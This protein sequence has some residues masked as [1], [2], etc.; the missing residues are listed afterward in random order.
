VATTTT[1][2]NRLLGLVRRRLEQFGLPEEGIAIVAAVSGGPDSV[3][4]AHLLVTL[5]ESLGLTLFIAHLNHGLRGEEAYADQV[6]VESLARQMS[7]PFDVEAIHLT[8]LRQSEGGNLQDLARRHRYAFLQKVA[9]RR[10]TSWIALGHTLDDQAET[11]LLAMV[12]GAGRQGLSGMPACRRIGEQ[13]IIRP[14]IDVER[15]EIIEFLHSENLSYR[16]DSSNQD[17]HYRR[18]RLRHKVLPELRQMNPRLSHTLAKMGRVFEEEE[19]FLD[20]VARETLRQISE[21]NPKDLEL[22]EREI[23]WCTSYGNIAELPPALVR[24]IVRLLLKDFIEKS[25][26]PIARQAEAVLEAIGSLEPQWEISLSTDVSLARRYDSLLL[27]QQ[28][29]T[30][31]G[32][33]SR[34]AAETIPLPTEGEIPIPALGGVLIIERLPKPDNWLELLRSEE[35]SQGQTIYLDAGKIQGGLTLR[36]RRPGDRLPVL[37][38]GGAKK[39]KELMIEAK[40]PLEEREQPRLLACGPDILW[41]LGGPINDRYRIDDETRDLLKIKF[42]KTSGVQ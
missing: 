8:D 4:M 29:D 13:T 2:K 41:L 26:V 5:R 27:I 24:R 16:E 1:I 19:L 15:G 12:R 14:L 37:G 10:R 42:A 11:I 40:L 31:G 6:F 35:V 38:L 36:S 23:F 30:S 3:A 20:S 21:S 9:Q 22:P 17:L 28:Q 18:N 32:R 25:G 33:G 7:V 34:R 39:I